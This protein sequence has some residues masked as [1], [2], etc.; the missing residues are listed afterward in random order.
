MLLMYDKVQYQPCNN[1]ADACKFTIF[2]TCPLNLYP[3][4]QRRQ[5]TRMEHR[6]YMMKTGCEWLDR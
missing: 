3:Q 6:E 2:C 5:G 4:L 1:N